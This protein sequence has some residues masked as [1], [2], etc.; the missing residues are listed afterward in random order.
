MTLSQLHL[1]A[2]PHRWHGSTQNQNQNHNNAGAVRSQKP[3]HPAGS[4]LWLLKNKPNV[5]TNRGQ[6]RRR[7]QNQPFHSKPREFQK[8]LT[9]S[10][11]QA[12]ASSLCGSAS[13]N[14][15]SS[16][17]LPTP[18]SLYL[19][20]PAPAAPSPQP[21]RLLLAL[22]SPAPPW[23]RAS[24]RG[25]EFGCCSCWFRTGAGGK[26]RSNNWEAVGGV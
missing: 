7:K 16:P 23:P 6:R 18:L 2:P 19:S 13:S 24:S 20:S 21:S 11:I 9:A 8:T 22:C 3:K 26:W 17:L 12:S 5:A 1:C 25:A 15:V 10:A 4:G 14:F